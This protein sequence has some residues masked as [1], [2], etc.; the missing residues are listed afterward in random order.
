[1]TSVPP[2]FLEQRQL[3]RFGKVKFLFLNT[4]KAAQSTAL[5]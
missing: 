2:I 5:L 1:M 3:E 4:K